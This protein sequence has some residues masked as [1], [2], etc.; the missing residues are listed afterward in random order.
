MAFQQRSQE[1]WRQVAVG[2]I[3][4]DHS[5]YV[6]CWDQLCGVLAPSSSFGAHDWGCVRERGGMTSSI[7]SLL[8]D[9]ISHVL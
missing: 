4:G 5:V 3:L 9:L 6:V 8:L 1:I 2:Y 7:L